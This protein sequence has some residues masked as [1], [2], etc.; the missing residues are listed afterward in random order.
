MNK[1][2][3][4]EQL[5]ILVEKYPNEL[6]DVLIETLF[7]FTKSEIMSK[8]S[9]LKI[10]RNNFHWTEKEIEFVREN[11]GKLTYKEMG[12]ELGRSATSVSIR[13]G[14]SN[15][16]SSALWTEKEISVLKS[17]YSTKTNIQLEALMGR[18][19]ASIGM[20]A[21]QFGLKKALGLKYHDPDVFF[22][23]LKKY[24]ISIGRTP[25]VEEIVNFD[26]SPSAMTIQRYFGGYRNV[27]EIADLEL[28]MNVYG[29]DHGISVYRSKNNDVCL[30][31]SEL[32][33]T[34]F[35]IDNNI[36]YKKEVMYSDFSNDDR[37]GQKRCDWVIN[38]SVVVEYF[39]LPNLESYKNK[40]N[41]KI[42]IC[43]NSDLR[44]IS[45]MPR[46]ASKLNKIFKEFIPDLAP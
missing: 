36:N 33:I 40:M 10:K 28:N 41:L 18:D 2:W 3:S 45:L 35:F 31:K 12:L 34:N 30:S 20:K 25:L 6:W 4:K 44:L 38:N 13:A 21:K 26:W 24:A 7:P 16:S 43:K 19:S 22:V 39:G 46:D 17:L 14:R 32:S 5:S 15:I 8:A 29:K 23:E 11:Y 9:E 37:C 1:K 42:Q 27:C